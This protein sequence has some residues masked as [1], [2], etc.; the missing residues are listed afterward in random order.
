MQTIRHR[1]KIAGQSLLSAKV[2]RFVVGEPDFIGTEIHPQ[3]AQ[4]KKARAPLADSF[5]A[6]STV[7]VLCALCG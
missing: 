4:I 7:C 2:L 1:E 3:M 5:L 6:R